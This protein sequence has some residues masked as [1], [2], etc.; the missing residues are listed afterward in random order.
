MAGVPYRE[1]QLSLHAPTAHPQT[2]VGTP[3]GD[4]EADISGIGP[5]APR[6]SRPW[7]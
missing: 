2:I 1:R 3:H 5:A 4:P 6:S 7:S